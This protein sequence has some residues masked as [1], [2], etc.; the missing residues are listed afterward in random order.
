MAIHQPLFETPKAS[1]CKR[2][3]LLLS[4]LA[5]ISSSALVATHLIRTT[6]SIIAPLP[7]LIGNE[8]L[9]R[10]SCLALKVI[11][12][13]ARSTP[14][15]KARPLQCFLQKTKPNIH[16]TIKLAHEIKHRINNKKDRAA[17][18]DCVE[19]MDISIDRVVDSIK[20]LQNHSVYSYGDAH[21]WLSSVLTNHVTCLDGLEG[22]AK[23]LMKDMVKDLIAR[24]RTS[25]AMLVS[26]SPP[27]DKEL[28]LLNGEF[29]TWVRSGDRRLLQSLPNE[30]KA[31]VVVAKDGS[32]KYKTV[33]GAV[34][35]AP[36]NSKV[37]Y[38][39]YVKK[40]IYKENVEIGKNKKNLMLVGDGMTSTI[41]T[42]SLNYIDGTT[43][44]KSATVA[45]VGDGFIA[46]DIGFQNTAGPRKH[47]AVALRVGADRSV[48]NRCFIAAYQDTLYAHSNRQFYKESYITG[49]VDFIFGNAAV[50]FQSC[51]LAA[52]RPMSGQ[53]NMVTA[54][55]RTDKFQNTGTSI[56]RCEIIASS[57]LKPVKASF[58]T[59]L[60]RPWKEYSRTVVMQST[61]GNHIDPAGWSVWNDSPYTLKTL[62][63]GEYANKGPGAGLSKRVKWPG[64]HIIT[65]PK[66]A[67]KFTV[68]ELIQGGSWLK[69]TGVAYIEGL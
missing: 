58:P 32:G 24:A 49:T 52:R 44:F 67:H 34:D 53:K 35:S 3:C 46:Q 30:I 9:D 7:R 50:V 25:L 10:E 63:Y 47:Q 31:N 54:Q 43:T 20:A 14:M 22:Q 12:E 42:G 59:Y 18:N 27:K 37:R 60:G 29:P 39:I 19:L 45:A 55:G 56:Q 48:I 61:I 68:A 15:D 1:P 65:S 11:M 5:I 57:D 4:L 38:I 8:A 6:F 40:G 41:I 26:I 62:Y 16:K 36:Q 23:T 69:D 28:E 51:K 66:E 64:Y 21:A 33:K 2:L 17:I 13:V